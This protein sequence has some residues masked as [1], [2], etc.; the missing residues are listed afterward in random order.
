MGN[1]TNEIKKISSFI[2]VI[3]P[4]LSFF[5]ILGI[6]IVLF[7]FFRLPWI[8]FPGKDVLYPWRIAEL[9]VGTLLLI[10][11]LYFFTWGLTTITRERA[12]GKEIGKSI[13]NSTIITN[14]AF[15]L[16]RHPITLG[17]I[18]L[19]PGIA[20]IFDFVPLMLMTPFYTPLLILLLFYEEKELIQ[21]FG[22]SYKNYK[23]RV[24]LLIPKIKK[25]NSL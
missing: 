2:I 1:S 25:S 5:I 15:A 14:G 9:V 12:S 23:D 19:Q 18:F 10:G 11:G 8:L 20:F 4:N 7:F 24:P 21:R 17:F 6:I 16:C 13:D 22:E 3:L